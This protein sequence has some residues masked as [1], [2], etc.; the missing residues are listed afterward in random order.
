MRLFRLMCLSLACLIMIIFIDGEGRGE[1]K[2]ITYKGAWFEIK[3]PSGFTVRPARKSTTNLVGYDSVYFISP[4]N[5]VEFYVFS[6][7][8][9]GEAKEIEINP[10]IE[11]LIDQSTTKEKNELGQSNTIRVFTAKAKDNSYIR[12]IRDETTDST[13]LIFGIKYKNKEK[14]NKYYNDYI[15]FKKS[16]IQIAD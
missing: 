3:Y 6:P 7:Q 11:K 15:F 9:K 1:G 2:W 5:N 10:N 4:D 16:L 8:W 13:R 14:Y 12:A